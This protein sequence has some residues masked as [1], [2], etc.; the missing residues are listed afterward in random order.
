M[1]G[2]TVFKL[3]I[4]SNT[5]VKIRPD[6]P[7]TSARPALVGIISVFHGALLS[8]EVPIRV[9]PATVATLRAVSL[10]KKTKVFGIRGGA[11]NSLLLG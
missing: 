8:R 6:V 3:V 10:A 2:P 5:L 1:R 11:I 4:M 7:P 9:H